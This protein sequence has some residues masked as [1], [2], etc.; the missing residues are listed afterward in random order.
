M[1]FL[2]L[3][4]YNTE[5]MA[6]A[7]PDARAALGPLCAPHDAALKA[8]GKVRILGSFS[9]PDTWV[10]ILPTADGPTIKNGQHNPIADQP[11][12]F[13]VIEAADADEA[14]SVAS[15]HAAA[16]VGAEF[17]FAVEVRPCLKYEQ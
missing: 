13:L 4:Y 6:K 11:G 9:E 16:N 5:S 7:A 14:V 15:K 17:G 1:H 10:T 3:L 12:A 8:T 2:C